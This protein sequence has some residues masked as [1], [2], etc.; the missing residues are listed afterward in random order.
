MEYL[1][2]DLLGQSFFIK[3]DWLVVY[4]NKSY[5]YYFDE[6]YKEIYRECLPFKKKDIIKES[7]RNINILLDDNGEFTYHR[8][9]SL[10]KN[11]KLNSNF[12]ERI[13][14]THDSYYMFTVK[15]SIYEYEV[16]SFSKYY[17][18]SNSYGTKIFHKKSKQLLYHFSN[19][20]DKFINIKFIKKE[21]KLIEYKGTYLGTINMINDILNGKV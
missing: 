3:D 9:S 14:E 11:H 6:K 12:K 4:G 10:V 15:Y 7:D 5:V 2:H 21:T 20:L 13:A 8:L 19:T 16:Y 17:I 18:F 1:F